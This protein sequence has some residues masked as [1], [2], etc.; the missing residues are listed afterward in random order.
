MFNTIKSGISV[1]WAAHTSS[2]N[3]LLSQSSSGSLYPYEFTSYI[4]SGSSYRIP[5]EAIMDPLAGNHIPISSSTQSDKL[6]L[7]NPSFH[8]SAYNSVYS[9]S[10][11]EPFVSIGNEQ[12]RKAQKTNS[13]YELYKKASQ[14]F[15][16]EI[17]SFFL[18]TNT[19]D[20]KL[21]SITSDV[22]EKDVTLTSGSVYFM[23]I[24]LYKDKELVMIE[25]YAN[26]ER[27][28]Y[29]YRVVFI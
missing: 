19:T 2:A 28:I 9:G 7:Q 6:Y 21:K 22:L 13:D 23:D 4:N 1:D 17:P 5:F 15:F 3:T 24:V 26:G 27:K 25:D 8:Y 10:V 12:R 20:G 11:R 16:A 29:H 18:S 14:N